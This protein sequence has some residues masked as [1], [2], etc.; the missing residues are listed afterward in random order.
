MATAEHAVR[1]AGTVARQGPQGRRPRAGLQ[2]VIG[3]R[4]GRAR[5]QPGGHP[6]L[7]GRRGR[8][9][10]ARP[11][12]CSRSSR[13]C[14]TSIGYSELNKADPD[15]GT[16]FTWATRAFGPKTGWAGGWGDRR[17]RRPGHGQPGPGRRA[18]TCSC[19]SAPRAS[20]R[21]PASGWVL[22]AGIALDR[23]DDLHLLPRHRGLGELPEDPAVAS[24]SSCCS[25]CRS[26]ALVKV[27]TGHP[28][29]LVHPSICWLNPFHLAASAPSSAGSSSWCSSTGAGTPR[30]RSTRRP[31][32]RTRRRAG[33]RSSPPCILLDHLRDRDLLHPGLRRDRHQRDRAGQPGQRRRRAVGPG[34]RDL[35]R[36]RASARSSAG[37]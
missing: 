17:R 37:C 1:T 22:L 30:S 15:C 24:S 5:L 35:R 20:A 7:R 16:T 21:T 2:H 23:R 36:R 26:S 10:V 29:G 6:G 8:A 34:Q 31:R 18:S 4:L 19:C 11:S 14:L 33:R 27:G 12:P 9:P 28:A 13:C 3:D 25:C 32:T